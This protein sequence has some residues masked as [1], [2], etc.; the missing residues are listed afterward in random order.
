[1]FHRDD[2]EIGWSVGGQLK[3]YL[4][5]VGLTVNGPITSDEIT[6]SGHILPGTDDTYDLGED[7]TPLR[8][9]NLYLGP[10]SLH[11]VSTTSETTTARD[12]NLEIEKTAGAEQGYFRIREGSTDL[13]TVT[14]AG[15][16]GI[17]ITSPS[18]SLHAA[19]GITIDTG[20]LFFNESNPRIVAPSNLR[21]TTNSAERARI[22]S[23]GRFGIGTTSPTHSLTVNGDGYFFGDIEATGDITASTSS[24]IFKDST[25]LSASSD[26][27]LL[28]A[29]SAG[30]D[31]DLL[32][33]GGT[34]NAFPALKRVGKDIHFRQADDNDYA[35][36]AVETLDAYGSINARGPGVFLEDGSISS[37]SL[38][39]INDPTKG[40]YSYGT[41]S[42]GLVLSNPSVGDGTIVFDVVSSQ[43]RILGERQTG[44]SNGTLRL[45]ARQPTGAKVG[46]ILRSISPFASFPEGK[47]TFS[48]SH[49][50]SP[51]TTVVNGATNGSLLLTDGAETDFDLLQLGGTTSPYPALKRVGKNIHFR[52]ADDTDYASV[53]VE[54]LDAYGIIQ[55]DG[56][57][58]SNPSIAFRSDSDGS[59][60]GIYQSSPNQINF[61]TNGV[62]R[63][64]FSTAGFV[65][66]TGTLNANGNRI[67][68]SSAALQLGTVATTSHGLV[69]GDV[70]VG[71]DL[72]VDGNLFVDG[73]I[74]NT[75]L[76]T[77]LD[78]YGAGN[79]S[80]EQG[81]DGY[82]AFF[83]GPDAI[84]GDNDLWWWFTTIGW[85]HIFVSSNKTKW[86]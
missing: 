6:A 21:F 83:T 39:F 58:A 69:D 86:Y 46:L 54:T 4:D 73:A 18:T 53:T 70:L 66:N 15:K 38:S 17:G 37:P 22:D 9:G 63:A 81:A 33:L 61:T 82:I 34:T 12:Y 31:F 16:V 47:F 62:Q 76:T 48:N 64:F 44:L 29:N 79:V 5:P 80:S 55:V 13:I 74:F 57:T 45:G 59:G 7:T 11:I 41:D 35:S 19:T 40:F 30:T 24:F 68:D 32:Q 75:P 14:P 1:M 43:A 2:D 65:L 10:A 26:G 20:D 49:T 51:K 50:A 23:N 78:A 28:L 3:M 36:V 71:N 42:V 67:F 27:N 72:E 85:N 52:L 8:W 60:T 56:G 77:A 25:R 84:A